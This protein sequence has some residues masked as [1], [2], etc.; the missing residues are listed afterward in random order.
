MSFTE[1]IYGVFF[2]PVNTFR[3]LK[4]A[5]P[6]AFSI[7]TFTIVVILSVIIGQGEMYLDT[8]MKSLGLPSH[9]F[10]MMYVLAALFSFVMLFISAG[11][12]A[13]IADIIYDKNNAK[14]L[15]VCL[16]LASLPGLLGAAFSYV[17]ALAGMGWLGTILS[18]ITGI[19]VI[20]LQVLALRE[21]L[22]LTTS[23]AL[24]V[25]FIPLLALAVLAVLIVIIIGAVG[26]SSLS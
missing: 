5:K 10:G 14:G 22:E 1:I 13:L 9:M 24:L 4:E 23:G 21:A 7:I 19:W 18:M 3:Y 11:L 2:Q 15:L 20:V 6:L 17:F 25:F 12:Y 8:E 16:A 26:L